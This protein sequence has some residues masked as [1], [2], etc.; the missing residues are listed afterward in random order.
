MKTDLAVPPD[1]EHSLSFECAFEDDMK[2]LFLGGH[3]HEY[4]TR[5]SLDHIKGDGSEELLY[6]I[7]EWDPYMRDAPP[8]DRYLEDPLAVA[9]G[10]RWRTN[11]TWFNTEDHELGF[12]S[13]MCVTFGMAYPARVAITCDPD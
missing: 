3:M 12:P 6:D 9:A 11:C 2:I 4:G 1:E 7:P 10:D 13:E 5:F 8:F